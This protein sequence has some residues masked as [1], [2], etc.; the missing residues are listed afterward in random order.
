MF[1]MRISLP[2]DISTGIYRYLSLSLNRLQMLFRL[3]LPWI[4]EEMLLS[5]PKRAPNQSLIASWSAYCDIDYQSVELAGVS[6][7]ICQ[8]VPNESRE[9]SFSGMLLFYQGAG[10]SVEKSSCLQNMI[11]MALRCK[12]PVVAF[13]QRHVGS[14]S[15]YHY[16]S[17]TLR[18]DL[19]EQGRYALHLLGRWRRAGRL[20]SNAKLHVYGLCQGGVLALCSVSQMMDH[21]D[22]AR[23]IV[24]RTPLSFSDMVAYVPNGDYRVLMPTSYRSSAQRVT[25]STVRLPDVGHQFKRGFVHGMARFLGF[26]PAHIRALFFRSLFQFSRW[27][28]DCRRIV[29]SLAERDKI[30]A[31]SV[32]HDEFVSQKSD[33]A[34]FLHER[35]PARV[36]RMRADMDFSLTKDDREQ[37]QQSSCA[38]FNCTVGFDAHQDRRLS[39]H[40]YHQAWSQHM[41][42]LCP[43]G[44]YQWDE[45]QVVN[46]IIASTL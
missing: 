16:S 6:L 46:G 2:T 7:T 17:A 1:V 3:G 19:V 34:D 30:Y 23:V 39:P 40:P 24:T 10:I 45:Y 33:V 31:I 32:D 13:N 8:I 41:L 20:S 12:M 38:P 29:N 43:E 27:H 11:D 42:T 22:F 18:S 35:Q 4:V 37:R 44:R 25:L 26:F 21:P 15:G 14:S 36:Y 5:A 9:C 28:I